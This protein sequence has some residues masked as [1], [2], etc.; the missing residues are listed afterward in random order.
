MIGVDT[1]PVL[2]TDPGDR[3]R[4]S[5]F[6]FT[7]N[8]FEFRAA[9][10]GQSIAGP[11]T[12]INTILAEALD[13]MATDLESA[14]AAGTDFNTAVQK[15]LEEVITVH[16]SA[17][18]NGDG[19]SEDWQVEAASRGLPN[20]RT[21]MDALPELITEPSMELFEKYGVFTHAEMHSRFE[22]AVEQYV[23]SVRV[24]ARSTLE[25]GQTVILPAA[26]RYQTEL[27]ANVAALKAAGVEADATDLLALSTVIGDL[28]SSLATLGTAVVDESAPT[29]QGEGAHALAT[30]IPAMTGVR[31]AC[32]S[33]ESIVADDLWPLP[34]YQEM[35]FM[36]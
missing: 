31:A 18:F 26:I 6:A 30:L 3:N 8:R 7:G 36:L 9:G 4:T 24:E 10:S 28:R 14:V 27:A 23:L 35:L 17:V 1:L 12:T 33:L 5:P 25:I 16:G 21:T 15:L 20:L 34:T 19:Y 13:Y 11:M 2:P 22:I 29:A 32:D